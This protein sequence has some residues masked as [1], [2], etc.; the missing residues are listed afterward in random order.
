MSKMKILIFSILLSFLA[1]GMTSCT[2]DDVPMTDSEQTIQASTN[3]EPP[4]EG[5][6]EEDELEPND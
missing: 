6:G 3:S 5:A 4:S 1:F 2:P